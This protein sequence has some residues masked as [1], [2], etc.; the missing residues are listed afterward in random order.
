MKK[1][2]GKLFLASAIMTS[3]YAYEASEVNVGFIGYK[4]QT[5]V[6]VPGVFDQAKLDIKSDVDFTK[7][8]TSANVTIDISTLNT[9]MRMRDNNITST[10]FKV[11][12]I[13]EIKAKVVK[14][15]GDEMKGTV[16][17][18]IDMNN[19]KKVIPMTYVSKDGVLT[20]EGAIDVIDFTMT[21]SLAAFAKKCK[22][23]HAGKTWSEVSVSF[24][25]PFKK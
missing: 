1:T 15:T 24:T 19:T 3:V 7:F 12:N 22:P 6:G 9:K 23:F 21:E 10:L 5:K 25:L 4:M 14:V 2:I 20:A 8:L 13:K 18:E 16:D 17:V 11:A